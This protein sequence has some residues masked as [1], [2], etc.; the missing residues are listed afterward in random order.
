MTLLTPLVSVCCITYNQEKFIRQ[1]V[2]SF[3]MQ[4]TNFPIEIIIHD[5]ASTDNT[6]KIVREYQEK[7]P[8]LIKVIFQTENQYS[9]RRFGFLSDLFNSAKGKYIALCEGDDYWTDPLKLQKQVDFLE[10]NRDYVMCFHSSKNI[11]ERYIKAESNHIDCAE[12]YKSYTQDEM[13]EDRNALIPTASVCFRKK[14]LIL[15][16]EFNSCFNADTFIFSILGCSGAAKYLSDI[17]PSIYR[18]HSDGV[19]SSINH[20]QKRLK[21]INTYYWM[22]RYYSRIGKNEY[23]RSLQNKYKN[24]LLSLINVPLKSCTQD[25]LR[26]IRILLQEYYY[27]SDN[28]F[29]FLFYANFMQLFIIRFLYVYIRDFIKLNIFSFR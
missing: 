21:S 3:L 22:S 11:D 7:Y 27:R 10:A 25:L 1:A 26:D 17:K 29:S 13:I 16:Q 2:D 4:Q 8:H 5:D 28:G 14:H 20:F 18:L 12:M 15:P 9:L 23:S 6:T 19:W 24:I